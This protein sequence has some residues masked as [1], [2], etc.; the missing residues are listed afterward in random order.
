VFGITQL[1]NQEIATKK[2]MTD[3]RW[4]MGAGFVFIGA[5]L[6]YIVTILNTIIGKI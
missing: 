5:E 1:T 3:L 2:D 6:G 4:M